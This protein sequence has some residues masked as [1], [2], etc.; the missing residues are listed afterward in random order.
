M[1]ET[2]RKKIKLEKKYIKIKN[3]KNKNGI[4]ITKLK[5]EHAIQSL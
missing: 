5:I 4:C 2:F 3:K 1:R